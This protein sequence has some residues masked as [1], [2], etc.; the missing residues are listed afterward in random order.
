MIV[1]FELIGYYIH[2]SSAIFGKV[3]KNESLSM[4]FAL[5]LMTNQLFK[6]YIYKL[7]ICFTDSTEIR[8]NQFFL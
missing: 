1:N 4:K 8:P 5:I 3:R 6:P 2:K 7:P